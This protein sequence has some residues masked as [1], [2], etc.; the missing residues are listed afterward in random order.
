[1]VAA[2]AAFG[3]WSGRTAMNRRQILYRAAEMLRRSAGFVDAV[4]LDGRVAGCRD[5]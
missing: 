5:A 3:G 1:V 2:R 4:A